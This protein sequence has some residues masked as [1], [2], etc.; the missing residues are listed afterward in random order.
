MNRQKIHGQHIKVA[1]AKESFLE[2]LQRERE[3]AAGATGGANVQKLAQDT[4]QQDHQP[5]NLFTASSGLNKRKVFGDDD[6]NDDDAVAAEEDEFSQLNICKKSARNSLYNG[7]L[8]IQSNGFVKPLHIIASSK[9]NVKGDKVS[10]ELNND[11]RLADDQKRRQTL[12]KRKQDHHYKKNLINESLKQ[13]VSILC[14]KS[15]Q[16]MIV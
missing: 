10:N 6:N 11:E 15:S 1:L 7:R 8:V 16:L 2:R 13:L 3:A 14:V 4:N 9:Q 12:A 5:S